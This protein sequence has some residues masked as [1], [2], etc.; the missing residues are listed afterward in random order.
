DTIRDPRGMNT[1]FMYDASD[2]KTRM[3]YN[4]GTQFRTWAYD[5]ALNL[6]SRNTTA[7]RTQFFGYDRRNRKYAAWWNGYPSDAEWNFFG[8]SGTN[9]VRRALNGTGAW[10]TN[11][12]AD[13]HRNYSPPGHC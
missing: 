2:L 11:Y 8:Y 1:T 13:V 5:D 10:N 12:I 9:L 7:G 3:T 6:K 4:G